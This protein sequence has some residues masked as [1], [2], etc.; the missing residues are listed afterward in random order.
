MQSINRTGRL[1]GILFLLIF[2]IGVTAINYRG[3]SM[4]II[5]SENFLK[6]VYENS[7]HMKFA[8]L[9]DVVS[10]FV[11]IA[12]AALLYPILK[13]YH[14]SLA[15]AFF[16]FWTAQLAIVI[17]SNV[18]HLS[19]ISLSKEFVTGFPIDTQNY[20]LLGT[21]AVEEYYWAHYFIIII[22]NVGGFILHYLFYTSKLLPRMLSIWGILAAL[23]AIVG[24][25][26]QFFEISNSMYFFMPNGLLIIAL[27]ILSLIHI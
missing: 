8:I 16:A 23:I 1:V 25:L 17:G 13:Q 5:E 10:S 18:S 24:I 27:S 3:L 7:L 12:I 21:L 14:K 22:F 19:L 4:S 20:T 11:G 26:V 6:D 15:L 2:I 9:L